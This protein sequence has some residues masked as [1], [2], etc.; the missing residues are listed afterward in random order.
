MR[1]ALVVF[2]AGIAWLLAASSAG[3]AGP[4][5]WHSEQPVAA[6]IEAPALLGEV[7]DIEF[8]APNRGVLI[9]AGSGSVPAGVYAY[10]G[11]GWHL[12]STV[13]GGHHGRIAWAGPTEFWTVSD[14]WVGEETKVGNAE[15]QLWNRSLCHFRN[16][17]VVASYA[18]PLGQA[19]SYSRMNA[20]TCDGPDDCWFGGERLSGNPNVGAFH[21]HW[22]GSTL[23]PVPSLTIPEPALADPGR[24]VFAMHFFQGQLFESVTVRSGDHPENEPEPSFLHRVDLESAQ[25]FE[26]LATPG[27][28]TGGSPEGLQGFRFADDG[29]QLWA[30]SGIDPE[31]GGSTAPTLL[32]LNAG[33]F[34]QTPL[35]GGLFGAGVQIGGFAMEPG[36]ARAW[37][38]FTARGGRE[39]GP[40]G[41]ARIA[42]D[43]TVAEETRLPR[44]EE[45]LNLKGTAGPLACPAIGQC[46]M[47][48]SK[49]W[50]FHLGGS[51]PQDT[52]PAM[53]Q[54]ITFRPCD[55]AC[56][57]GVEIG[58]PEDNSGAEP[59]AERFP[60]VPEYEAPPVHE[61]RP[62]PLYNHL[63]QKVI[64]GNILQLSF[65][66]HAT[67]H[68]QLIAKVKKTV[69]AKTPRMT[70]TKGH[71][72]IRLKL[73][74][75]NWPTHLSF[76]VHRIKKKA[77]K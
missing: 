69:V 21:L 77:S 7:G 29:S 9:T 70:L 10:D 71:H 64:D 44:T 5:E 46:W 42:A 20:A 40:A 55:A 15:E 54:L 61:P 43:G 68:V 75:K 67:A 38:S 45:E 25:P 4:S 50:L 30:L 76:Q 74:P 32:K 12:Y 27:L 47:A 56:Q 39:E 14:Q 23:S 26:P 31:E 73:D 19:T 18:E 37:A 2:A 34:V 6:G 8:E 58:L 59:E 65:D 3:A 24:A 16:G 49:G 66:L 35:T 72:R 52:D 60:E 62:H 33:S 13:C 51:L 28:V 1:R 53:H 36:S 17:E 11:T 63:K 41:V 48:T 22:N 57:S